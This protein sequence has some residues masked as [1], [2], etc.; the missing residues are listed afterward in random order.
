MNENAMKMIM[1][2]GTQ[3]GRRAIHSGPS[4]LRRRSMATIQSEGRNGR[5]GNPIERWCDWFMTVGSWANGWSRSNRG[6]RNRKGWKVAAIEK[7]DCD[8]S[9]RVRVVGSTRES[10]A[11]M[12]S[13]DH[14]LRH[15][16]NF[17]IAMK[18]EMQL[19]LSRPIRV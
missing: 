10:T 19:A 1:S 12:G 7:C 3:H 14:N 5:V 8:W 17:A 9:G 13:T 15:G 11:R 4:D 16:K 18:E 2:G 6:D